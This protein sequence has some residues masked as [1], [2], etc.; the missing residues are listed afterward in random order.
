MATQLEGAVLDTEAGGALHLDRHVASESRERDG[1]SGR[2][3]LANK[4]VH[5]DIVDAIESTGWIDYNENVL[6]DDGPRL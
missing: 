2:Y 3:G 1:P 6:G 5:A 4:P